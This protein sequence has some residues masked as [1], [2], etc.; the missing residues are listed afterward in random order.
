LPAS[1]YVPGEGQSKTMSEAPIEAAV[2]HVRDGDL[3]AFS[4]VVGTYQRRLRGW[5]AGFCPPGI[6][7]D[8]IAQRAFITAYRQIDQYQANTNFF[9]WL[10]AIGRNLLLAELKRRQRQD[11]QAAHYLEHLLA[12]GLEA[13]TAEAVEVQEQRMAALRACAEQLSERSRALLAERYARE[14]PL[15]VV[16]RE[17]GKTVAAIK[18]QLFAIRHTLR[19]C[20]RRKLRPD[21]LGFNPLHHPEAN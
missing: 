1:G 20:V 11:Q 2:Q 4:V 15:D 10:S 5:L 16:A 14:T 17:L 7:P 3:D 6:E 8:E 13:A 21:P 19:D 18:F 12:T 9:A